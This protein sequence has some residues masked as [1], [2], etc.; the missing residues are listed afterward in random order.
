MNITAKVLL[1]GIIALILFVPAT[2]FAIPGYVTVTGYILDPNGNPVEDAKV[3]FY[4]PATT[5]G[6]GNWTLSDGYYNMTIP[7]GNYVFGVYPNTTLN[8]LSSVFHPNFDVSIDM[9]YNVTLVPL[10]TIYQAVVSTPKISQGDQGTIQFKIQANS[11]AYSGLTDQDFRI[12]LHDWTDPTG[13]AWW[14]SGN[15]TAY[16]VNLTDTVTVSE[17]GGRPGNYTF[18]FVLPSDFSNANGWVDIQI[19]YGNNIGWTGFQVATSNAI[20]LSGWITANN[21]TAINNIGVGLWDPINTVGAWTNTNASGYYSLKVEPGIYSFNAWPPP[22]DV[23]GFWIN[24]YNLIQN[25]IFNITLLPRIDFSMIELN[26]WNTRVGE[27]IIASFNISAQSGGPIT[28]IQDNLF[29]V[30]LHNWGA[31]P[32]GTNWWESGLSSQ[33]HQDLSTNVTVV[34]GIPGSY[35]FTFSIPSAMNIT[36]GWIDLEVRLGDSGGWAGI[37][38]GS[39]TSVKLT[40]WVKLTNGTAVSNVGIGLWNPNTQRGSWSNTNGSGYF[41]LIAEPGTYNIDAW[42]QSGSLGGFFLPGYSLTSDSVYNITLTPRLQFSMVQLNPQN[43][44]S[45]DTISASF[46]VSTQVECQGQCQGPPPAGDP[47]SGLGD[48]LFTVWLHNWGA[49]PQGSNWWETHDINQYHQ[50]LSSDVTVVEGNSGSYS[51]QFTVP[52]G[53][54][55][56]GGWMDLEVRL[57]NNGGWAG[58]RLGSASAVELIGWTLTSNGT[59]LANVDVGLWNPITNIGSGTKSNNFGYYS[60][61]VESGVYMLNAWPMDPGLGGFFLPGLNMTSDTTY[62][63]TFTPRAMLSHIEINPRSLR[64]GGSATASFNVTDESTSP[65]LGIPDSSFIVWLHNWGADTSGG[66]W[67]ITQTSNQYHRELTNNVTVVEYA[68]GSYRFNFTLPSNLNV[69]GGFIDMQVRMGDSDGWTGIQVASASAVEVSGYVVKPDGQTL[70]NIDVI[71]FDPVSNIDIFTK[72]NPTGFYSI[73][74]EPGVYVLSADGW[75]ANLSQYKRINFIVTA[76]RTWNITLIPQVFID[77]ININPAPF[78]STQLVTTTFEVSNMDTSL[79]TGISDNKFEIWI[80]NLNDPSNWYANPIQNN[81]HKNISL[82]ATVIETSPGEYSFT[83]T[84]PVGMTIDPGQML[85]EI[86]FVRSGGYVSSVAWG[87]PVN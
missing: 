37:Q 39:E 15:E 40:G 77:I 61:L 82:S 42:P 13:A 54:N 31:E 43:A 80:H 56:T 25:T 76:S 53:M 23:G 32:Q 17:I 34:E 14:N 57:G 85:L 74:V 55:I 19:I 10:V 50:D 4:D 20:E 41:S 26:P 48:E 2:T 83:F 8:S 30:W 28:G 66:D 58:L 73:L 38:L 6:L 68:P 36:G 11:T 62:N 49:E 51:F 1:T 7:I 29:K 79:V 64:I 16:H 9:E 81:Y 21:G 45:T 72:S 46:N 86:H 22:S 52:S 59:G 33:Y 60:I 69:T 27:T 71:I 18:T 65:L 70:R 87:L 24:N 5:I 35:R 78:N 47:I 67:W 63:I 44:R 84:I 75:N 12:W 3:S